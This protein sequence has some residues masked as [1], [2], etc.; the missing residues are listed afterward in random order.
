M[1]ER[2]YR[3]KH[4][5]V[6]VLTLICLTVLGGL[7][8]RIARAVD[9]VTLGTAIPPTL[10]DGSIY[11]FG[12]ALG[13]FKEEN[14]SLKIVVFQ[15]AGVVIP[16]VATKQVLIGQ[17]LPDPILA[18][19]ASHQPVPVTFFYNVLPRNTIQLG[20]LASGPIHTIADLKGKAIGVGALTWGTIPGTKALLQQVGLVPGKDVQIVP[21]GILGSGFH[22]LKTGQVAALNYNNSWL[23]MLELQGTKVRRLEYPPTFA[24]MINNAYMTNSETLKKNPDIF[25][26]FG[27]AI[28]KATIACYVNPTACVEAFWHD[29][30]EAKP[31]TGDAQENL[32]NAVWLLQRRQA[33]VVPYE[34]PAG[35]FDL[36]AIQN[37]VK[38]LHKA[39]VLKSADV[40]VAKLFSNELVPQ[41]NNFDL[42]KVKQMAMQY[43]K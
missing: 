26:R 21:V 31:K 16:Q 4:S 19:Y 38:A 24:H 9:V 36:D 11:A 1:M 23:D 35:R 30:P 3:H 27:R 37:Y 39:G 2:H 12:E 22:A 43:G 13:F 20:V 34:N 6:T 5:L 29:H 28:T 42:Q 41:F 7:Q 10:T 14:I 17:P 25:A 8:C 32:R 33:L 40:P 15:G 18:S